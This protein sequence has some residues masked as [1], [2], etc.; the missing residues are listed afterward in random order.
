MPETQPVKKN[1]RPPKLIPLN[2]FLHAFMREKRLKP[3]HF[4][5]LQA[6]AKG[7]KSA[8]KEEW[9]KLYERY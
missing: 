4:Q 9:E 7:R 5:G 1:K 3:H 8:T 2:T 6:H